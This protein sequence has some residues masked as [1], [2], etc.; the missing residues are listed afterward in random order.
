MYPRH[1]KNAPGDFYVEDG[2]CTSCDV[3]SV[4]APGHFKYDT[5][6]HCFVCKQPF[7]PQE[8]DR[9]ANAAWVSES[10]CI[11]YAGNDPE[12]LKKFIAVKEQGLCDVLQPKTEP[13]VQEMP[14]RT[15]GPRKVWWAVWRR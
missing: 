11:R 8:A 15:A 13:K 14:E 12:I 7:T 10:G 6:G 4:E 2:C 9:M 1:T 3:P 5:D